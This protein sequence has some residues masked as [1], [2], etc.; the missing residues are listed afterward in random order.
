ME[1]QNV[2]KRD[3]GLITFELLFDGPEW[4]NPLKNHSLKLQKTAPIAGCRVGRA[5]LSLVIKTYGKTLIEA[6]AK[7]VLDASLMRAIAEQGFAPVSQPNVLTLHADEQDL[8]IIVSFMN[9]PEVN[10]FQYLGLSVEKPIRFCTETDI[11]AAVSD[12]LQKHLYVHEV[13]RP[14]E[15]GDIAEVDFTGT[16]DGA[17]FEFDHSKKSR[18]TMGSGTLFAG[19]D[20]ALVGHMAGDHLSLSLTM[21]EDFHRPAVRG[22]TLDLEVNLHG[23]WARDKAEYTDQYV[24]D[25][26]PG[27]ETTADFREQQRAKIQKHYDNESTQI[28]R[29]NIERALAGLITCP[30]PDSMY[31]TA[32]EKI[33]ASIIPTAEEEKE[34][35]EKR[36]A[37][38]R[39]T[40]R[41]VAVQQV[42]LSLALDYIIQR[43]HIEITQEEVDANVNS[44]ARALHISASEA[45]RQLGGADEFADQLRNQK[46]IDFVMEHAN[47]T[48]VEVAEFPKN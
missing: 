3:T 21:P 24:H 40:S 1:V 36:L 18:F 17:G 33:A 25:S 20:E 4:E 27:C 43:E 44:Y 47:V 31:E 39:E 42:K 38:Y 5:P 30:I 29:K 22:M 9:Y 19:L 28:L 35:T 6:A 14:A 2:K 15:I 41:P 46:A 13:D 7:D 37:R 34:D 26:V 11:D 16:H 32:T 12:Y 45:L 8:R 23:V 10:D 48:E